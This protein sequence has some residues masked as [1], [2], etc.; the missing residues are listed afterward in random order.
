MYTLQGWRQ[1]L[2]SNHTAALA[3][4]ASVADLTQGRH[5]LRVRYLPSFDYND[6]RHPSFM[7]TGQT[8]YFLEVCCCHILVYLWILSYTL[9]LRFY[10]YTGTVVTIYPCVYTER[11]VSKRWTGRLG[12]RYGLTL[13]IPRRSRLPCHHYTTQPR[14]YPTTRPWPCV[15]G[16]HCRDR[17]Y[18]L[19]NTWYTRLVVYIPYSW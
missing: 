17:G 6:I 7:V 2:T 13:H 18:A 1:P 19:A 5:T 11:G 8:S 9:H 12:H 14:H 10:L 16:F 15:C 4:T 3:S